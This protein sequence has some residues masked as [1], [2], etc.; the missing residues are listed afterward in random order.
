MASCQKL[1]LTLYVFVRQVHFRSSKECCFVLEVLELFSSYHL[2]G[3]REQVGLAV[4]GC[5]IQKSMLLPFL[6]TCWLKDFFLSDSLKKPF[7]DVQLISCGMEKLVT[8]YKTRCALF[9]KGNLL[10]I[11]TRLSLIFMILIQLTVTLFV[12]CGRVLLTCQLKFY[13][14]HQ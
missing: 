9:V 3:G 4:G 10:G 8:I 14:W 11:N 12:A 2:Q 6:M 5:W 13:K 1:Y 7:Y